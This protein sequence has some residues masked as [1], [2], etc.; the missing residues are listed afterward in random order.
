MRTLLPLA[1]FLLAAP[2]L[3]PAQQQE[4]PPAP[5]TH[6]E[7]AEQLI[8]LLEETEACLAGCRDAAGVQAALPRLRKL[9]ERA[10]AFKEAQNRLPE[11]TTHDYIAA[12]DLLKRFNTSWQAIRDHISRLRQAGLLTQELSSV[13]V[14]SPEG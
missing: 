8:D 10:Q 9:S 11:P 7:A 4:E 2:A 12:Q 13:L 6:Q 1:A 5:A 3:L 14:I